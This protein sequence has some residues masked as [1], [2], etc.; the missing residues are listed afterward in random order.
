MG[1][2]FTLTL[3]EK[4]LQNGEMWIRTPDNQVLPAH[5]VL[6]NVFIKYKDVD[7]N[8]T[9]E[10]SYQSFYDQLNQGNNYLRF[11]IIQDVIFIET[12]KGCIF[13]QIYVENNIVYP[14]TQNNYFI[15]SLSSKRFGFPSYW[16]DEDE[17]SIYIAS[18]SVVDWAGSNTWENENSGI[19]NKYIIEKFDMQESILDVICHFDL[20]IKYSVPDTYTEIPIVEPVKLSYNDDTKT[21][22]L[23][24]ISRGPKKQFG[25]ISINVLKQKGDLK[26]KQV[27]AFLPLQ[28][29]DVPFIIPDEEPEDEDPIVVVKSS[30]PENY[31]IPTSTIINTPTPITKPV[32]EPTTKPKP[33]TK[34]TTNPPTTTV[35]VKPEPKPVSTPIVSTPPAEKPSTKPT[36]TITVNEKPTKVVTTNYEYVNKSF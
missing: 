8:I 25:L 1:K 35:V 32:P 19:T 26:V 29:I 16:Y 21:F 7:P 34:P 3:Y 11:D 20:D 10:P 28:D 33:I 4:N 13:D 6:K 5:E 14:K 12:S 22:N 9:G 24:H 17:H 2:Y 15:T 31:L 27:N 23:S 18:N 30:S 36:T